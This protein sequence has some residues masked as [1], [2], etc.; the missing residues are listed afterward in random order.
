MIAGLAIPSAA[1]ARNDDVPATEG[2]P[3]LTAHWN[4]GLSFDS[5]DD[6][7]KFQLGGLI[8]EDGRFDV[9]GSGPDLVNT[10][11][12]RRVRPIVQGRVLG[13]LEFRLMPDFGNGSAVLFDGYFDI[14]LSSKL[15]IR[16]G[17]DKTQFGLEQLQPDY[18]VIVPERT[19]ASNL[20]PSRDVGRQIQGES[21]QIRYVA[22]VVNGVPDGANGDVDVD[23]HKE[24][25]GRV[26]LKY[27]PLDLRWLRRRVRR[28]AHCRCS[29]RPDGRHSSPTSPPQPRMV[30]AL[31]SHLEL[32]HTGSLLGCSRNTFARRKVRRAR[33]RAWMSR[34]PRGK[35]LGCLS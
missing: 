30:F 2:S 24:I 9:T 12:M 5:P 33:H 22:A 8:Q 35:S 13:A 21:G 27:G 26:V 19:L 15:R 4:N 29:R 23:R 3:I 14:R 20:V 1:Q 31:V 32:L 10:F 28:L 17:K 7:F 16:L 18:A 6:A 34:T 11:V 25:V